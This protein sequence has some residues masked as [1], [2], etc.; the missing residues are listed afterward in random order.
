MIKIENRP[1]K[2]LKLQK[3]RILGNFSVVEFSAIA[4]HPSLEGKNTK[5]GGNFEA[6]IGLNWLYCIK[7]T[8]TNFKF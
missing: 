1:I 7:P 6:L 2:P 4:A 5:N 3:C 8:S